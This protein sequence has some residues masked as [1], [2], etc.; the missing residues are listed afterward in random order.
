MSRIFNIEFDVLVEILLPTRLRRAKMKAFINALI[1]PVKTLYNKFKRNREENVY[2]L[3]H[4]AQ[5]YSIEAVLNDRFDTAMRRVRVK[6]GIRIH[7]FWAGNDADFNSEYAG[8]DGDADLSYAPHDAALLEGYDAV[9]EVPAF[10]SFDMDE[11]KALIDFY[12]LAGK[13][14]YKIVIV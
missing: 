9:I 10:I 6:D 11:M 1:T 8:N 12:R 13:H 3:T 7:P 5:V 4:T 2:E 14:N